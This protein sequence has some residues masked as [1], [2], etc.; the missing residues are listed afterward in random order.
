MKSYALFGGGS[1]T[2][3]VDVYDA[4]L[5]R[6]EPKPLSNSKSDLACEIIIELGDTKFWDSK[7]LEYKHR[8]TEVYKKQV[9]D[10]ELL[11]IFFC[12]F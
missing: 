4:Y 3:L 6:T 11:I 1:S 2:G 10:L 9:D 7:D 8:M 5:T 12:T